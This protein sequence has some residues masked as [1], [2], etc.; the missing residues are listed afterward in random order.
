MNVSVEGSAPDLARWIV[1]GHHEG[2]VLSLHFEEFQR[3]PIVDA[4]NFPWDYVIFGASQGRN[5]QKINRCVAN[6]MQHEEVQALW[7]GDVMVMKRSKKWRFW[8]NMEPEDIALAY[9]LLAVV[10]QKR[11][12]GWFLFY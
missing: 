9:A 7:H 5:P 2:G 1:I 6:I 10:V 3:L 11:S 4:P 8:L 12:F